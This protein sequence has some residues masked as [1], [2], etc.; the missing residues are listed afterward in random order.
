MR[1]LGNPSRLALMQGPVP[2]L[3]SIDFLSRKKSLNSVSFGLLE[4]KPLEFH[5]FSIG[6]KVFK[7]Q[8]IS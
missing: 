4:M 5:Y 1:I 6:E 8:E 3:K 7:Y 2:G